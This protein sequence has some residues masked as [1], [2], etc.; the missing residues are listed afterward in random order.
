MFCLIGRVLYYKLI[1][2]T[3]VSSLKKTLTLW[4]LFMDSVQLPQKDERLS[5]P[6]SHPVVLNPGLLD[7]ECR[8]LTTRP[9]LKET[10]FKTTGL[11]LDFIH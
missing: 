9:L 1:F 4:P 6:W 7:W 8:A 3:R 2:D 11:V 10:V 5:R